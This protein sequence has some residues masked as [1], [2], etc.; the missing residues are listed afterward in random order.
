MIIGSIDQGSIAQDRNALAKDHDVV[1]KDH[2]S[3]MVSLVAI[4]FQQRPIPHNKIWL[5]PKTKTFED[6]KIMEIFYNVMVN[7]S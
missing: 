7:I 2:K 5:M 1:L 4:V 6:P 3:L